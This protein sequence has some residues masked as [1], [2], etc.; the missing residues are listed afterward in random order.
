MLGDHAGT[1]RMESKRHTQ[2]R[3]RILKRG[4]LATVGVAFGVPSLVGQASAQD[5][6]E[7]CCKTC[8]MDVKPG[9]CP[10][11][12]NARADVPVTVY[13][14][15]PNVKPESVRLVP[16]SARAPF[17]SRRC[18]KYRN[19]K[20]RDI[21]CADIDG[22]LSETDG[23]SAPACRVKNENVDGDADGDTVLTFCSCDLELCSSDRSLLLEAETGSG[24]RLLAVDSVKPVN[25]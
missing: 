2:S 25:C 15:W 1:I 4:A 9:C 20:W 18:Q 11:T 16:S 22:L 14:G 21:S 3:R 17:E 19:P 6:T 12:V 10:N 23:R 13:I 7:D 5:E 24:C 8:W